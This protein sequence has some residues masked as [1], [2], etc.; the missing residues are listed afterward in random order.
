MRRVAVV[1]L[2]A[3][4][5]ACTHYKPVAWSRAGGWATARAAD[6]PTAPVVTVAGSPVRQPSAGPYLYRVRTGDS[7][8]GIAERYGLSSASLAR[9]NGLGA[10]TG[11]RVGTFLRIPVAV[12]GTPPPALVAAVPATATIPLTAVPIAEPSAV[13]HVASLS[14]AARP[15]AGFLWPVEGAVTSRFGERPNG[16]RNNGIDIAAAAGTA[17]RAAAGGVVVYAG[18]GIAGYGN[19]L[20]ISHAG[21]FTTTYA[22]NRELRVQVGEVVD[23]GQEIATVGATGRLS[24]PQLHFEIREGRQPVDPLLHLAAPPTRVASTR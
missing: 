10:E 4:L 6:A 7:L 19:M 13:G 18:S 11:V 24:T 1:I 16:I 15:A 5:A 8:A 22:Y 9:A 23:R 21:N 12:V 2:L 14:A 3:G 17:V 20:L